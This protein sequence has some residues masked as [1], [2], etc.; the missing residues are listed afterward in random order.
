[1]G[2]SFW[3]RFSEVLLI[4]IL[5]FS[6]TPLIFSQ[7][8]NEQLAEQPKSEKLPLL[9]KQARLYREQGLELQQR[10]DL[11]K[12]LSFYRK[13]QEL[14]P[15][16]AVVYNDLG[17][18]YEAMNMVEQAEESY[19]KAIQIDPYYL[20]P[21][22]NLALLYEK[23]RDLDKA[24][25]YWEK[26]VKLGSSSDPWTQKAKQRL[27]DIAK[28]KGISSNSILKESEVTELVK[29]ILGERAIQREDDKE[30]AKFYF[31]QAQISYNKADN[32][33]A[34]KK[35][36][37]ALQ[38]DPTNSEIKRFIEKVRARLLSK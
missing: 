20:S 10:G 36:I 19:L 9:Q 21:Y 33:T 37:D 15:G 13:A 27:K 32:V 11:E 24:A 12:A 3:K 28:I 22:S 6:Y 14:D 31:R 29:D 38:L 1:M 23:K 35:A 2:L 30:L 34:L 26:R 7:G 4:I 5:T 16:Y 18:I 25:F 8:K 17:I